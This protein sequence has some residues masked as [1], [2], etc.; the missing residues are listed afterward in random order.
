MPKIIR[1]LNS[2]LK[3]AVS[4]HWTHNLYHPLDQSCCFCSVILRSDPFL[5]LAKVMQH[6]LPTPTLPSVYTL[7]PCVCRTAVN[8]NCRPVTILLPRLDV[9]AI[10]LQCL[11]NPRAFHWCLLLFQP[12]QFFFVIVVVIT[13]IINLTGISIFR[14]IPHANWMITCTVEGTVIIKFVFFAASINNKIHTK[15]LSSYHECH[16][17]YTTLQ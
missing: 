9:S 6:S 11:S 8:T 14:D 15:L 16:K 3:D 10:L 7:D 4:S 2:C 13:N 1:H 17:I 5:R 12:N